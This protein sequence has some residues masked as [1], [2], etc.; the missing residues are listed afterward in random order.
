MLATASPPPLQ[1]HPP[2]RTPSG[3]YPV[4]IGAGAVGTAAGACSTR[5]A[6]RPRRFVVSSP[7]VWRPARRGACA[8]AQRD[9]ADPPPRRRALQERGDGRRGSTTRWSGVSA[10]RAS[11]SSRSAAAWSATSPASPR[12]PTCAA[13][14]L[15]Q[16]PTTLLA[17]V[18]SA[19]GG[20]VGVNHPL[21]K[22]LIGAFH[23]PLAVVVDP[24]LL[25]D[26]AA[27]RV[28]R[29]PLRSRQIRRDR[30][31]RRC[32]IALAADLPAIFARDPALLPVIAESCRIKAEVVSRGRAR[33]GPAAR[34]QLRPHRR[35]RARGDHQLPALPPRR[36]GRLRHAGRRR[37]RRR[38]RRARCRPT[39]TRSPTL[40]AQMGP[41]PP[42]ADLSAAEALEA[43]GRDKK[44]VAGT[45]HFVLPTSIGTTATVDRCHRRRARRARCGD[46]PARLTGARHQ[47]I[48]G[49]CS[50]S[51]ASSIL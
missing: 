42:V 16:V 14:R 20:K 45:L 9:A 11:A 31:P 17:Q 26:A 13:F 44:V 46:R 30:Q 39:A 50:C 36:S 3:A 18:D 15:V 24:A 4:E 48:R 19:I 21:G 32:S 25:G 1:P 43:T 2:S 6:R 27:P 40:I 47:P 35:P 34:P 29:R 12:P 37:A 22:N 49:R 41:L 5:C 7:P 33:G 23:Q 8:G 51:F 38:A 10:D 28:P